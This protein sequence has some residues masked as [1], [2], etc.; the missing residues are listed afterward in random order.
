[1]GEELA[2]ET[3]RSGDG[4]GCEAE[5]AREGVLAKEGGWRRM[6]GLHILLTPFFSVGC[7]CVFGSLVG[8]LEDKM[9]LTSVCFRF[10]PCL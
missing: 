3:G 5:G 9:G 7:V 4:D 1:M 8:R 2:V 6:R 10:L